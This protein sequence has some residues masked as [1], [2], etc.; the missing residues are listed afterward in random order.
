M[1]LIK[2]LGRDL[3]GAK[4]RKKKNLD[5]FFYLDV[6]CR[7]GYDMSVPLCPKK[8]FKRLAD[9]SPR[10]REFFLTTK[11]WDECHHHGG[12]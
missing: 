10:K 8:E 12:Y 9:I 6:L 1:Q 4:S 7:S 2:R 3:H 5:V 11:V